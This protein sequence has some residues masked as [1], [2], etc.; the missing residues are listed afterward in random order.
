MVGIG[1]GALGV[2]LVLLAVR[3]QQRFLWDSERSMSLAPTVERGG[4]GLVLFGR[5]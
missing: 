4:G 5:F 1:V 3:L 2:G